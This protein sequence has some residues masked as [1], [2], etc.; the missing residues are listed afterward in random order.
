MLGDRA[1]WPE[2]LRALVNADTNLARMWLKHHKPPIWEW[3]IPIR[4]VIW[5]M[6]YPLVN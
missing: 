4:M 6:V 2:A 3:F 5:G 1:R